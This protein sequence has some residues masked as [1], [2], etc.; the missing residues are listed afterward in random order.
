M[1]VRPKSRKRLLNAAVSI[2]CRDP[3]KAVAGLL[4]PDDL[5]KR[6]MQLGEKV[7][8][9]TAYRLW[10]DRNQ[11]VLAAARHVT[12]P[13]KN[14]AQADLE[15]AV[16]LYGRA[17]SDPGADV[18]NDDQQA[19]FRQVLVENFM[20]QFD[21]P[22]VPV[23]WLLHGAALT[24][25]PLWRGERPDQDDETI[26]RL[27][28]DARGALVEHV[29]EIWAGLLS[30][31]MAAY[32]RRPKGDY[33]VENI[34]KVMYCMFDG[35]LLHLFVDP[36]L[37]DPR[38]SEQRRL[39]RRDAAISAAADAMVQLAWAY[40]EPG[41]LADPRRPSSEGVEDV[42]ED[43]V[44]DAAAL[45]A[46]G[47]HKVVHPDEVAAVRG[48]PAD[49]ATELFPGPGDVADSVLRRLVA[50]AGPTFSTAG[51]PMVRSV[52]VRLHRT[53]ATHPQVFEVAKSHPPTSPTG[54][55]PFLRELADAIAEALQTPGVE[56]PQPH[57]S[58]QELIDLA[59]DA[60]HGWTGVEAILDRLD[61]NSADRGRP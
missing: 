46:S 29:A 41:S 1:K 44:D 27:V 3:I 35:C 34:V 54:T 42:F 18:S 53:V 57:V 9:Q 12:D 20:R 4:K 33:T 24:S 43:L 11:A 38:I 50:P 15:A 14:G 31:A 19:L 7:S 17:A 48:R 22:S 58:A 56:C 47:A 30:E 59:L 23:G 51:I 60:D 55:E 37:N 26:G 36:R 39:E 32:G 25:S 10:P 28:L 13:E 49:V 2:L 8:R 52:L 5:K 21:A 6:S 61:G 16:L 40:T 45:Y